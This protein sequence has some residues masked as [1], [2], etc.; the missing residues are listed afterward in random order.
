M[1]IRI[2]EEYIA[3][4]LQKL[5]RISS[6]NPTLDIENTGEGEIAAELA[7]L[8]SDLGLDPIAV[9][10][11]KFHEVV[12]PGREIG[13]T[14]PDAGLRVVEGAV[15]DLAQIFHLA[16]QT[17]VG[18]VAVPGSEQQMADQGSNRATVSELERADGQ[19][20]QHESP[21]DG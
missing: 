4:T 1:T 17:R 20:A 21:D 8:L 18:R 9:P 13:R 3:E 10:I 2:D 19:Q 5:V 7:I 12:E 16:F 11:E 15:V 6:T 14:G